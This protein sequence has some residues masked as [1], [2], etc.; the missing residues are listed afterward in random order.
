M[1][2]IVGAPQQK[3]S[4]GASLG[5]N[6]GGGLGEGLVAGMQG[7]ARRAQEERKFAQEEKMN[8]LKGGQTREM[9]ERDYG[10]I[11][12]NFGKKAADVWRTSTEGGKTEL[13]KK[14]IESGQRGNS[15]ED[16]FG[17]EENQQS[18]EEIEQMTSSEVRDTPRIKQKFTD[19]DKG[20]T[21]KERTSRQEH[22]YSINLPIFQ[23]SQKKRQSL[24]RQGEELEVLE[25]LSPKIG[26]IERLNINPTSGDLFIPAL[27][28]DDAQ[29]FVKT[30]N[31]FTINAKDSYGAR[32]TNFDL[33][34]FMRR[35]PTLANSESGRRQI[36]QQMKIINDINLAHENS[37]H[38]VI[39][40]YGGIRNIDMDKAEELARKRSEPIIKGLSKQLKQIGKEVDH[41][42][43]KQI[44]DFKKSVPEG[45]VLMEDES[46]EMGYVP[47]GEVDKAIKK[48]FKV[49]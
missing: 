13:L 49:L 14:F 11:K 3:E 22:R 15:V 45:M 32:V 34:S 25:E 30:V 21:P 20:L 38:E 44:S 27:A 36:I 1:V 5:R 33:Q 19:F 47:K 24:E 8:A 40:E 18:P 6:L 31:D 10:V 37:L 42:Y 26:A 39:D 41:S 16:L 9:E 4:F 7:M 28:S 23:E 2:Q 43:T 48:K 35:L 12:D 17:S 46:G 29:R